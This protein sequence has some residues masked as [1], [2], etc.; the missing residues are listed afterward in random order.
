VGVCVSSGIESRLVVLVFVL[1]L[2]VTAAFSF[3][4][5]MLVIGRQAAVALLSGLI[6]EVNVARVGDGMSITSTKLSKLRVV[7]ISSYCFVSS[8]SATFPPVQAA[9]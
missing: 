9:H 1:D 7:F 8:Q 6:V 4:M 2:D 3:L 5:G